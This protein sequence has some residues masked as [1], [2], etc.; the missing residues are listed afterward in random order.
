MGGSGLSVAVHTARIGAHIA[1]IPKQVWPEVTSA[2]KSSEVGFSPLVPEFDSPA[3]VV[4]LFTD[5]FG[6]Y[7]VFVSDRTGFAFT[8]EDVAHVAG[9]FARYVH[10]DGLT[11]GALNV[12]SQ[13]KQGQQ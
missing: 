1:Q 13:V 12:D 5:D 10:I 3:P 9:L 4:L 2:L 6:D 11:Q 8:A 7:G